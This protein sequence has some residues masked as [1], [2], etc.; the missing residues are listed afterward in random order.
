VPPATPSRAAAADPAAA[1]AAPPALHEAAAAY[2]RGD[3]AAAERLC[4]LALAAQPGL[5]EALTLLGIIK[6][7]TRRTA[8]A[9][10]LL[11]RAVAARPDDATANNNYGNVLRDLGRL[12]EALHSY[13]RA[14]SLNPGYAEAFS[15]RGSV[16]NLQARFTEAIDSYDRALQLRPAYA[17]AYYNRGVSL[18]E[19]G[20]ADLALASYEHA[21]RLRP[22]YAEAWYNRGNALQELRRPDEALRSFDRALQIRADFAEAWNNRGNALHDL[23]RSADALH[24]FERA[25]AS[26]P[27]LAA[28]YSNRGDTLRDLGRLEEAQASFAR[29]ATLQPDLPWLFGA[30]LHTNLELCDWTDLGAHVDRLVAAI[31]RGERVTRP[32]PVLALVDDPALQRRVAEISVADGEPTRRLPPP[33][34]ARPRRERIR[35]GYYSADYYHHA[36]AHLAAGLFEHHDRRRFELVAFSFG[37]DKRDGMRGRLTAAFARF[38]DVRAK[39]DQE[40]AQLSRDLEI[41]IAVDLK[42]FT[43]DARTGIFAHRAA[44]IQVNYLGYPGTMAAPYID[45]IIADH[46][47]IP[48]H[49]R[50]HYAEKVVFLP[51]SYQVNDR[52]RPVTSQDLSR[53]QLG[54]P[55]TGFVLC[56]F[57]NPVKIGPSTFAGWMRILQRVAGS[58][59]WLLAD[60]AT[61][62]RNLRREA[63]A[64]GVGAERLVFA[65]PLP[66][67]E[68]LARHRAA[69]LF[70]D[71]LPCN[72]H[73]TASD[74]LWA[75]LPVLTLSGQSFAARVAASLL[76][77]IGM[78][79]LI[80]A[81]QEQ[82]E[83]T[84]VALATDAAR[85]AAL[86][87]KL[88]EQR[89]A[90]PLFDVGR[91]T[92]RLESAYLQM[93]EGWQ[94]GLQP[95]DIELSG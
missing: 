46:A 95:Q 50:Q 33:R 68:H 3:W 10:D 39:S 70:V 4:T 83:A 85:L 19:T 41:D 73:T 52:Q 86:R 27:D 94:A 6:A 24:S 35:I 57:N 22:G 16:L 80:T 69:D 78:P 2:A 20:R 72:A 71:T 47:V 9:A 74:A 8:D 55:P 87:R 23:E 63:A 26:K 29:A 64:R 28:A 34:A 56:C 44:P 82:Y 42:G 91:Y 13:D 65:R 92:R 62:V 77:G 7:Q 60:D 49:S 43:Q 15:N 21:V 12:D 75:G 31:G 84:A 14:I 54:L 32:F 76:H 51:C 58:V 37:P 36:T 88:H 59:L 45:Y 81:T 89:L 90:A 18:H 30:R 53:A 66:L 48:A 5:F 40:V 67:A 11:Q 79:E 61:V 17:E 38:V 25:L 1:A 93:Y